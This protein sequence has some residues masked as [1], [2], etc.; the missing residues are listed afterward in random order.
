MDL[1]E[2]QKIDP[3]KRQP[4]KELEEQEFSP[5]DPPDAFSPPGVEKVDPEEMH[6]FL[7]NFLA[8]HKTF[9]KVI[10]KFESTVLSIPKDGITK[11]HDQ[12]VRKFFE[13]FDLEFKIHN[14]KEERVLFPLLH[15]RLLEKGEHS[16]G[17]E[18]TTAVNILEDDHLKAIQQTAVIFNFFAL[19]HRLPDQN[20]RLIVL[21]A[22]LEQSKDLVELLK[23]HIFREENVVF[24]L[25]HKLI[26]ADE[27]NSM[28]KEVLFRG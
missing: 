4:H 1:R 13:Y 15:K 6:I 24:P 19:S 12:N 20:S 21:D 9:Q 8:D 2:T 27:L 18:P 7:Q 25:A 28:S 26:S 11:E 5:M 14:R 10:D 3:L 22:A 17:K 16:Q 23:L